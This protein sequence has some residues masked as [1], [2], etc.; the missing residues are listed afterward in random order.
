M[1]ARPLKLDLVTLKHPE[2]KLEVSQR[3]GAAKVA[4]LGPIDIQ[5]RRSGSL[6]FR[7]LRCGWSGSL[8]AV[9]PA[10]A[11]TQVIGL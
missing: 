3:A 5:H 11:G 9:F 1:A 7:A 2:L 6:F 4:G 8:K 10:K